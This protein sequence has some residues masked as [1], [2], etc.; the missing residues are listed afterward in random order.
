MNKRITVD[1]AIC[2]GTPVIQGTRVPVAIILGSISAG[3][4]FEQIEREYD[5]TTDDIRAALA[6]ATELVE[7]ERHH[8]LPVHD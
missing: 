8:A 6:Y 2:H 7:E 1:P 3:M 5:V 4:N